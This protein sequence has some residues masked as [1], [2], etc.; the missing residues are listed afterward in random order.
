MTKKHTPHTA[1]GKIKKPVVK[2]PRNTIGELRDRI[3]DLELG[4][5]TQSNWNQSISSYMDEVR[6]RTINL[7]F[8]Y[9]LIR[10]KKH[11]K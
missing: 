10:P 3:K 7:P 2:K 6:K 8:G 11:G 9:K 5:K 1:L 4:I